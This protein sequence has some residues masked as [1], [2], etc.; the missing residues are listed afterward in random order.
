MH[1]QQN[2][3]NVS[4]WLK[5]YE[6]A[7]PQ[8]ARLSKYLYEIIS[9]YCEPDLIHATE[10]REKSSESFLRKCQ[11][12][13][14]DGSPRYL[15]PI[16]ELTDLAGVRAIVYLRDSVDKVC[17]AI[18][19]RFDVLEEID[20]GERVYS[21]GKF[22]YQSKHLIVKLA[23]DRINL[24]ENKSISGLVC[25][26]Q[27]RTLLQHAWAAIDHQIQYKSSSEIP[28]EIRK[29]FS[30]LA[31]AL[32]LAD[33]EL[34]SID[35]DAQIIRGSVVDALEGDLTKQS[36]EVDKNAK[37]KS[38]VQRII[39]ARSLLM[40]GSYREA[41][42][43]YNDK[44]KYEPQ[45][46][47]LYIGRAKARFLSGDTKNAFA[48]LDSADQIQI[49]PASVHLRTLFESGDV[50]QISEKMSVQQP[51][52]YVDGIRLANLA[53]SD[54]NGVSAFEEFE[55]LQAQGYNKAF[56]I[57]GKAMACVLEEDILGAE[58][59]LKL[60]KIIPAT[61]MSVNI[62]TLRCII[63]RLKKETDDHGD[64]R[65]ALDDFPA[66][67]LENSP[68]SS[69][70]LGIESKSRFPANVTDL[71]DRLQTHILR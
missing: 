14:D 57:F 19:Q 29:R 28:L 69:L 53:L 35:N 9:S 41:I 49:C 3:K 32:E 16:A 36:L 56:A 55:N 17:L 37:G 66:Y 4:Q 47:T 18:K 6:K 62:L 34:Q 70:F 15:D 59:Y 40:Q 1:E 58:S 10:F 68:I 71:K 54:G 11:K 51:A 61:P 26:V 48:D 21:E 7:K 44:L 63:S 2:T 23:Q 46:Y 65:K 13:N 42:E 5:R 52:V 50:R 12:V 31:G 20:V 8:Y 27:V 22:G 38:E 30:A 39:N 25:E 45:S 60:L 24:D 33:R 64:L 67:S 43:L